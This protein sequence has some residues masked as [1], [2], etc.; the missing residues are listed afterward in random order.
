MFIGA[1][2]FLVYLGVMRLALWVWLAAFLGE[3]VYLDVGA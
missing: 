3:G 2:V 1:L